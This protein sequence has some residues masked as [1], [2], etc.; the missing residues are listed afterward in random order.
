MHVFVV[1]PVPA[2][3]Y[4]TAFR[5][6]HAVHVCICY[7]CAAA[8]CWNYK[9]DPSLPRH[10][11]RI[12]TY[13]VVSPSLNNCPVYS[14]LWLLSP[15]LHVVYI[16]FIFTLFAMYNSYRVLIFS[17]CPILLTYSTISLVFE[18]I[19]CLL[20][21][22]AGRGTGVWMTDSEYLAMSNSDIHLWRHWHYWSHLRAK[23]VRSLLFPANSH[24]VFHK[25]IP[26]HCLPAYS[27]FSAW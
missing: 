2:K 7:P 26:S 25:I 16:S 17:L 12:T 8:D 19:F 24:V 10:A 22:W 9:C 23:P 5:T 4:T 11:F 15:S 14:F 18:L 20:E 21:Y 27:T 6:V 3:S 13:E 1:Y